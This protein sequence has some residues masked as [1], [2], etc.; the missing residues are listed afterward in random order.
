MFEDIFIPTDIVC[1]LCERRVN[2]FNGMLVCEH[3]GWYRLLP[4]PIEIVNN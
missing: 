2:L 1:P 3:C 4:Q